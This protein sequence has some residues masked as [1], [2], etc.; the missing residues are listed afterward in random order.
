MFA[1]LQQKYSGGP[2][3]ACLYTSHFIWKI[4]QKSQTVLMKKHNT[5]VLY[6]G[7]LKDQQICDSCKDLEIVFN[8]RGS[9]TF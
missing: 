6:T 7:L 4:A 2:P 3:L 8:L 1:Y 9:W 5:N